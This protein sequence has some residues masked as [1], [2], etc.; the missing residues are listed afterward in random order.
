V[1]LYIVALAADGVIGCVQQ[2]RAR[3]TAELLLVEEL[4]LFHEAEFLRVI[5]LT[6][7]ETRLLFEDRHHFDFW[8]EYRYQAPCLNK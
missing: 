8:R 7:M 2:V 1:G 3:L 6:A 4:D 5:R